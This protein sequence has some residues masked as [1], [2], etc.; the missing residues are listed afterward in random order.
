MGSELFRAHGKH[1]QFVSTVG[2]IEGVVIDAVDHPINRRRIEKQNRAHFLKMGSVFHAIR[3]VKLQ[4]PYYDFFSSFR[5]G[6]RSI[7]FSRFSSKYNTFPV[8]YD[9][10]D[11]A[12]VTIALY[13]VSVSKTGFSRVRTHCRKLSI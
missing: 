1:L 5:L 11:M 13:A 3:T 9:S 2:V 7:T 12:M 6:A 8:R 10:T 4:S